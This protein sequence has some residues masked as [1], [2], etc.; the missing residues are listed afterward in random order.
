MYTKLY[1]D[2]NYIYFWIGMSHITN[3]AAIFQAIHVFTCDNIFV[4]S[5][6]HHNIHITYNFKQFHYTKPIHAIYWDGR[7]QTI[8]MID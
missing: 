6:S 2:T 8:F 1:S 3:N 4:S 5:S 7:N